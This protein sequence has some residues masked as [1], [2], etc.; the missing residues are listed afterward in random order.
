MAEIT[1]R[2]EMPHASLGDLLEVTAL[3]ALRDPG[4]R[5]RAAARWL[6]RWLDARAD[7]TIDEAAF[8]ATLL[9]QLGGRHHVHALDTLRE[10]TPTF[11][12][13]SRRG[14]NRRR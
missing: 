14:S 4:R 5:S 1:L 9:Q 8:T 3:I 10:L 12:N 7:V 11:T 6:V 13:G 2:T